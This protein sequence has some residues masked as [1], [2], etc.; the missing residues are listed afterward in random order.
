VG[1]RNPGKRVVFRAWSSV[2]AVCHFMRRS[3]SSVTFCGKTVDEVID[4]MTA[5]E[6]ANDILRV[7]QLTNTN[8]VYCTECPPHF[9]K[10]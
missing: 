5:D 6:I 1:L 10:P 8:F 3:R 2:D 4:R 7:R 9:I